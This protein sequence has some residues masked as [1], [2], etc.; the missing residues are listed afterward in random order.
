MLHTEAHGDTDP[1]GV[2]ALRR[3]V[4]RQDTRAR[5]IVGRCFG[6]SVYVITGSLPLGDWP[7]QIAY[8]WGALVKALVMYRSC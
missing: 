1:G 3:R 7:Y 6:G 8:Q 4:H 2:D 5:I